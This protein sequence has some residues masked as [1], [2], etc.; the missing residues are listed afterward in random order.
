MFTDEELRCIAIAL[1]VAIDG[2]KHKGPINVEPLK[3]IR[4]KL[5]SILRQPEPQPK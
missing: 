1:D 5:H 3:L 2:F 4:H